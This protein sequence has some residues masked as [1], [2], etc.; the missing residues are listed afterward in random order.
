MKKIVHII[1]GLNMGGTEKMLYNVVTNSDDNRYEHVVVSM[2]DKGYYGTRLEEQGIKVYCLNMGRGMPKFSSIFKGRRIC[3]EADIMQTWMYH[4]NFFGTLIKLLLPG[5]KL[6][7]GIRQ[8]EINPSKDTKSTIL[9]SFANSK[10]SWIPQAIICNSIKGIE[11]HVIYGYMKNKFKYIPNGIDTDTFYSRQTGGKNSGK[12]DNPFAI[13]TVG[14]WDIQKG[15]PYLIEAISKVKEARRDIKLIMCGYQLSED[16]E[17]LTN[18]ISEAE[19]VENVQL[20]GP[21]S[22]VFNI[23]SQADVFILPSIGEGFSN[24]LGEAMAC[25]LP[26][27]VTDVGD[28]AKVLGDCGWVVPSCD[29]D[30][31]ANA[32][33]NASEMKRETLHAIGM[34]A[35]ERIIKY[36]GIHESIKIFEDLY[37]EVL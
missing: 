16:N 25:E 18:L 37:E 28:S 17:D 9:A 23:L 5:K 34:S 27:I 6:I 20:I 21:S 31:I 11:N 24:A 13:C 36:Y 1:T 33:M 22:E 15:Y 10:L 8:S 14:R 19:I 2:M 32:I 7:W 4:A 12:A 3:L 26:C 29:S 30:A 35:R